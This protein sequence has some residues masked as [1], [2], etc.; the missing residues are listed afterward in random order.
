[1]DKSEHT[2]GKQ[3]QTQLIFANTNGFLVSRA[4]LL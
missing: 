3:Q 1:M 2:F 4:D